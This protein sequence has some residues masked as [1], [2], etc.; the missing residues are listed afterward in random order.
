MSVSMVK[1]CNSSIVLPIC[2]IYETCLNIG[3]LPDYWK[4]TKV[5]SIHKKESRQLKKTTDRYSSVV[6][7]LR[8][9][10]LIP[11]TEILLTINF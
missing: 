1:I 7:S 9:L 8:N 10:F 3:V 2:L 4:K 5:L 6:K 11:Y